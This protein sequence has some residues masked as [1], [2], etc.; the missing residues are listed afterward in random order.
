[1]ADF[2]ERIAPYYD[3]LHADLKEDVGFVLALAGRAEGP[4]LELGC[5]TGRLLLPLARAGHHVTGVDRSAAML[6]RA[7]DRLEEAEEAVR[8]RVRLVEDDVTA[9]DLKE[10]AYGLV[11]FSYNT[12]LHLDPSSAVAACRTASHHL[13]AGGTL[14]IDVTNPLLMAHTPNDRFLTLERTLTDPESGNTILVLA[15]NRVDEA[16]QILHITWIYDATPA[17][18]GPV[19]RTIAEAAY[20]YYFPHQMELILQ[21]SGFSLAAVYGAYNETAFNEDSERLLLLAKKTS[22]AGKGG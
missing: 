12:F 9:F 18:S 3:L 6:R 11:L 13:R 1:M 22:G 8:R 15:S 20:H 14:F 10:K 2:Y 7:R 4:V 19:H 16:A 21:E 5:G 17:A